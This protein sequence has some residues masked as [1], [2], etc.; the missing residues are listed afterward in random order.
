MCPRRR[1]QAC[2]FQA[3]FGSQRHSILVVPPL[4]T[5]CPGIYFAISREG[6]TSSLPVLFLPGVYDWLN[7]TGTRHNTTADTDIRQGLRRYTHT[8]DGLIPWRFYPVLTRF[9]DRIVCSSEWC[10]GVCTIWEAQF[11]TAGVQQ[12][13]LVWWYSE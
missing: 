3:W 11:E 5:L 7:E 12:L 1:Q 8:V 9:S 10:C 4:A 13:R 6:R 2:L